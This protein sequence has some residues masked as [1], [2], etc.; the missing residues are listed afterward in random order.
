MMTEQEKKSVVYLILK[1][2]IKLLLMV[3]VQ[4]SD[5]FD[6]SLF[7][8]CKYRKRQEKEARKRVLLST[9]HYF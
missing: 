1:V 4:A 7:R 3:K 6:W 5:E 9:F 2:G 8:I